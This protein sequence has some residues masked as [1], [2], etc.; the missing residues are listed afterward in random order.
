MTHATDIL[1]VED[2][3]ADIE[4][5]RLAFEEKRVECNLVVTRNGAEALGYLYADGTEENRPQPQLILLD[6][7]MPR[8]NG[9]QFLSVIRKDERL[10]SIPVLLLTSSKGQHDVQECFQMQ[11][12]CYIVKP[13]SQ[14]EREAM[15]E[16]V[17]GFLE[18]MA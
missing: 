3:E 16:R 2:N 6:L 1:L 12:S 8:M 4:L 14:K 15:V 11:A 13:S 17:A 18:K 7:N 10:Q 5:T 9:K